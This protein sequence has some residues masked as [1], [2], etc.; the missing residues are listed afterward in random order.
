VSTGPLRDEHVPAAVEVANA[1]AEAD[2]SGQYVTLQDFSDTIADVDLV[3]D[4]LAVWRD[5]RLAGYGFVPPSHELGG[6]SIAQGKGGI[7]PRSRRAG[8]GGPLLD[9]QT[10]RARDQAADVMDVEVEAVNAGA[11][12]LLA[13]RDFRPVRYF[14]VMRRWYDDQPLSEPL[15]PTG[16]TTI[17][18]EPSYDERLRLAHNEIFADSWGVSQKDE[19]DWRRWFT[20]NRAFRP[21]WSSVV[22]EGDRIAA[23]ALGYEFP[24]DTE[25]TGVRELWIGQ[26]GTR[27]EYRGLGL[28]RA[29]ITAV[30]RA[31]QASSCARSSLGVDTGNPTGATHLYESLGFATVTSSVLHRLAV[32][33]APAVDAVR[34]H[35]PRDQRD[36]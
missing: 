6:Q 5:G 4:S 7:H 12:A 26:V 25:L 18:F 13:D 8:L 3:T 9:W 35:G 34:T 1:I 28:A 31:G 29:A 22:L 11:R 20:G 16:F 10:S 2:G 23:Y 36:R 27:H 14:K 19:D 30:L 33:A 21:A 24:I 32:R 17:G 15:V